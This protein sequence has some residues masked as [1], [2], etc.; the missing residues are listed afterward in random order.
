MVA[1]RAA[2]YPQEMERIDG[3][4]AAL[5][6]SAFG[7]PVD[8]ERTT[9]YVSYLYQQAS[10]AGDLQALAAVEAYRPC[11]RA[12]AESRR[13]LFVE[14]EPGVQAASAGGGALGAGS[15]SIRVRESGGATHCGR[16]S[17]FSTAGIS[18][19]QRI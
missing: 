13:S 16:I 11:D 19:A 14:S 4:I 18:G 2:G 12:A 1:A 6:E 15:G 8:T 3:E 10:L 17:I 7:S 5:G 9:K